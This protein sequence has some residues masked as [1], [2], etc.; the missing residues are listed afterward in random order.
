MAGA[1]MAQRVLEEVPIGQRGPLVLHDPR[2]ARTSIRG[3]NDRSEFTPLGSTGQLVMVSDTD[4]RAAPAELVDAAKRYVEASGSPIPP[5]EL[6]LAAVYDE[7]LR[8]RLLKY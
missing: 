7:Q 6:A 4:G 8:A 3:G 1:E 5:F 2:A